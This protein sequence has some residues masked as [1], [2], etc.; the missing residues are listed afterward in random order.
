MCFEFL[1]FIPLGL[2]RPETSPLFC[3]IEDEGS[4]NQPSKSWLL[5]LY[6][7]LENEG[8]TLPER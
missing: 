3:S 2:F 7:E 1:G 6:K 5:H 8:I 4:Q